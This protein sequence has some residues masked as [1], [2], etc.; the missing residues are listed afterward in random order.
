MVVARSFDVF[1]SRRGDYLDIIVLTNITLFVD[2]KA[3]TSPRGN[4]PHQGSLCECSVMLP[5]TPSAAF[6]R[7]G[8]ANDPLLPR[9][10]T[11]LC[12]DLKWIEESFVS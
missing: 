12:S 11:V 5:S 6:R 9:L 3:L 4:W 10:I 7:S 8:S 2:F 1:D